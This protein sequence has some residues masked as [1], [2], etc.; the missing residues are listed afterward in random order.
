MSEI[1]VLINCILT[2]S[3][4]CRLKLWVR[5]GDVAR[6]YSCRLLQKKGGMGL[7][8]YLVNCRYKLDEH[9]L[10]TR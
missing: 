1:L 4:M 6:W 2:K 5:F 7:Y 10:T 8:V 3:V 9:I